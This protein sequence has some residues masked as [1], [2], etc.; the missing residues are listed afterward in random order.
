MYE[1]AEKSGRNT[2]LKLKKEEEK[3]AN[4]SIT[5]AGFV[6]P[7][8]NI[9]TFGVKEKKN[10]QSK[11]ETCAVTGREKRAGAFRAGA[12]PGKNHRQKKKGRGRVGTTR[13]RVVTH[14]KKGSDAS[15]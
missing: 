8:L 6:T 5:R 1:K 4:G 9:P 14:A 7:R 3:M 15:R 10:L 13:R 11:R 12:P 2:S